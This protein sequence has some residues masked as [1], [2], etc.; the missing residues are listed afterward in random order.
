MRIFSS[1]IGLF[2]D[3][4]D[5]VRKDF[6]LTSYVYTLA[7]TFVLIFLNYY[8]SFFRVWLMFSFFNGTS[9]WKVPL[10]YLLIYFSVAIPVCLFQKDFSSLRNPMFYFK[11]IFFIIIYSLS[12]GLISY[13]NIQFPTFTP[14]E[15]M[16]IHRIIWQ[17]KGLFFIALPLL[18]FKIFYD[19]SSVPG[20]YGLSRNRKYL[21]GYLFMFLLLMPFLVGM[22]F[23][24]DLNNFYPIFR[25]WLFE[26]IFSL[27][28]VGT[29]LVFESAYGVNFMTTELFFRGALIL[30]MSTVMGTKSILPMI[31]LY[32]TIHF[33]KPLAETISSIF[34]GY[35]LGAWA[36]QNRHI[37]GGIIAHIGVAFT[38]EIMG[39]LH[40]YV[41]K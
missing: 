22:S 40:Y 14:Q 8:F 37:W 6:H 17:L 10:F 2:R 3:G 1:F 21:S 34:G 5:F 31:T 16:F 25:P 12:I 15:S 36:Y 35:L 23:T 7:I 33:G 32:A 13:R 24:G 27:P 41:L 4:Y 30:G 38:M 26:G 19:K 20:L 18:L 29:T 28:S 11:G 39:F 9:W